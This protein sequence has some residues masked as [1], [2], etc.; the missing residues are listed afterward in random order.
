MHANQQSAALAIAAYPPIDMAGKVTPT[1][2][3][4]IPYAEIRVLGNLEGFLKR[5]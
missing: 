4:E 2:Q 5:W 1:A 3:I